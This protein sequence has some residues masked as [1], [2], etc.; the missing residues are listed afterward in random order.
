MKHGVDAYLV[1]HKQSLGF[2]LPRTIENL[3]GIPLLGFSL[4]FVF[5]GIVRGGNPQRQPDPWS[6]RLGPATALH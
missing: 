6:A 4:L 3:R 2:V 5:D 1:F